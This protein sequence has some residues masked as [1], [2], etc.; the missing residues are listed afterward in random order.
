MD[1]FKIQEKVGVLEEFV[2][3]PVYCKVI[4]KDNIYQINIFFK[5]WICNHWNGIPY[6]KMELSA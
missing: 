6:S 2:R 5:K 1:A 4:W 3:A